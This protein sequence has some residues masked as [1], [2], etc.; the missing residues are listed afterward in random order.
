[1]KQNI[2][3]SFLQCCFAFSLDNATFRMQIL[4][5]DCIKGWG[6]VDSQGA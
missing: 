5:G 3:D 6:D 4:Y 2:E 1:M